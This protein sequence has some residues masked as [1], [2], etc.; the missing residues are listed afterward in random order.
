[1]K[2]IFKKQQ[3]Y[4]GLTWD[5]IVITTKMLEQYKLEQPVLRVNIKG[6]SQYPLW[7]INETT[8]YLCLIPFF[9]ITWRT[10]KLRFKLQSKWL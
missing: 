4:F 9:P 2:I 7:L 8:W 10:F 6:Y 1:M 3:L 5:T